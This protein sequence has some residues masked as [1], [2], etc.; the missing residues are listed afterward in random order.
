MI[1]PIILGSE[2]DRPHAEKITQH[3]DEFEVPHKII[4]ASAHK[5]P[6]KVLATLKEHDELEDVC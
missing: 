5:V 3:L 1:V 2:K 6:E 4:I